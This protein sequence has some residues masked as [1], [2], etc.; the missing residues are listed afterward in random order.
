MKRLSK[1]IREFN[2]QFGNI[3]WKDQDKIQR[4]IVEELPKKVSEDKAY[5][6]AMTNS[7]R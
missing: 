2:D 6:N 7:D 5:Q 1:I 4:V 3:K